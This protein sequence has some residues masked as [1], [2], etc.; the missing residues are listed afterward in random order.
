MEV[1]QKSGE[2]TGGGGRRRK[3][4]EGGTRRKFLVAPL[5]L[6]ISRT[7]V[8]RMENGAGGRTRFTLFA[9]SAPVKRTDMLWC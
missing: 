6:A 9:S 1:G 7:V 2:K 8:S 3:E 5:A 4:E